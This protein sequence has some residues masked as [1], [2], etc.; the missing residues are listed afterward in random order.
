M[1][2]R[3]RISNN[4]AF[5]PT[6]RRS[7]LP[8]V[9]WKWPLSLDGVKREMIIHENWGEVLKDVFV[10]YISASFIMFFI[11]ASLFIRSPKWNPFRC[12]GK[13]S[14]WILKEIR[15]ALIGIPQHFYR[16]LFQIPYS[17]EICNFARFNFRENSRWEAKIRREKKRSSRKYLNW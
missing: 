14:L 2:S 7:F 4:V 6:K 17:Y 13:W 12:V 11:H 16:L 9:L 10:F 15:L 5:L 1:Y 8:N 3:G